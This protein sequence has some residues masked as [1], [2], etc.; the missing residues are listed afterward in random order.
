MGLTTLTYWMA[1]LQEEE[2]K[3]QVVVG[4]GGVGGLRWEEEEEQVEAP[5]ALH[6]AQGESCGRALL[7][8][9]DRDAAVLVLQGALHLE[10]QV[11]VEE[12]V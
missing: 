9:E 8:L 12:H 5:P 4:G 7:V 10:V 3:V 1:T 2:E 6:A 11:Q